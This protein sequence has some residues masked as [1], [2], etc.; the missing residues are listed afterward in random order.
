LRQAV[1]QRQPL[2]R[3]HAFGAAGRTA[4]EPGSSASA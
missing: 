4:A 1:D 3:H 2:P